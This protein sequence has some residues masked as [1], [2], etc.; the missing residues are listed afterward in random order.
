[1]VA[2]EVM[3]AATPDWSGEWG[4][5]PS[6]T[7]IGNRK[8]QVPILWIGKQKKRPHDHP[9]ASVMASANN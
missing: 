5:L 1:M 4:P 2:Q 6:G 8:D 9:R 7:Q 3:Y